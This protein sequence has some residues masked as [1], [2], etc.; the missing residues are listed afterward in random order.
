M[1]KQGDTYYVFS[2]G[3]GI[4]IRSSTDLIHWSAVGRVFGAEVPAWAEAA[5]PGATTTWAPDVSFF[6]GEYHVYYAVST[7]GSQQS[8]IGL[9]TNST[10]DP[11]DPAY[12]WVDN[13]P[14]VA[15]SPGSRFNAID[16]NI[17]QNGDGTVWLTFGS[18]WSGI[19]QL[20]I[21]P[22]TGLPS[23]LPG[24]PTKAIASRPGGG[25]IEA[26][27]L[28]ERGGWYYLFVSFGDA[29]NGVKSTYKVMVGRSRS[30]NGP[31]VDRS[32]RPMTRGGGTLVLAGAGRWRGPGSNGVLAD[33]GGD[34]MVLQAVDAGNQ[35]AE[36]LQVRPL[37]WTAAGWPVAGAPLP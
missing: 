9:A 14:I 23:S 21:D 16:P 31:F 34:W 12:Q 24:T 37:I 22:A 18:R 32:G 4:P 26:P 11:T 3:P 35:G 19:E 28:F 7:Y 27:F 1:I 6:D 25:T 13:G 5:V 17:F 10:L 15:S 29:A 2:S 8:E 30:P 36:T 33:G 20:S